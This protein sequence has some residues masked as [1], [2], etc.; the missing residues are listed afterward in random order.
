VL[1][2]ASLRTRSSGRCGCG[3]DWCRSRGCPRLSRATRVWRR[4]GA[5]A[6][7]VGQRSIFVHHGH[8]RRCSILAAVT[9]V[10]LHLSDVLLHVEQRIVDA[11]RRRAFER[12]RSVRRRGGRV[13]RLSV[14]EMRDACTQCEI[15]SE[16]TGSNTH[17]WSEWLSAPPGVAV[18]TAAE[19]RPGWSVG[20]LSATVSERLQPA[21]HSCASVPLFSP[22]PLQRTVLH[23]SVPASECFWSAV[24]NDR[25]TDPLRVRSAV[26][27][28]Q[29][30]ET[31]GRIESKKN[32]I[33]SLRSQTT[34]TR[35][36]EERAQRKGITHAAAAPLRSHHCGPARVA[37]TRCSG[38]RSFPLCSNQPS[39][40]TPAAT[41]T[42]R[43]F[44]DHVATS[45]G[46]R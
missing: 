21:S 13:K 10:R 46:S 33:E 29:S 11:H 26:H 12:F 2:S 42:H 27:P 31:A 37:E 24:R 19:R 16:H 40:H 45:S 22:R 7:L 28:D 30:H 32:R 35:S 34:S 20:R 1:S 5:V 18:E 41:S 39:N 17:R 3:C 15:C 25:W 6:A 4:H 44:C 23:C 36:G 14:D 9:Q 8:G 43:N 38:L